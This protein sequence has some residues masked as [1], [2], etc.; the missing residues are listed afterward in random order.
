MIRGAPGPRMPCSFQPN[1]ESAE[2]SPGS[3][4]SV[5]PSGCAF[6]RTG[7]I[8]MGRANPFGALVAGLTVDEFLLL[9]EAVDERR[10]R[11]EDGVGTRPGSAAAY[12]PVPGRPECG[13]PRRLE[14]LF[15]RDR[16]PE[17]A[18]PLLRQRHLPRGNRPRALPQAARYHGLLHQA[19][20]TTSPS[21]ARPS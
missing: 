21:S 18:L 13:R 4:F 16:R 8:H 7:Q 1:R 3:L 10:C 11:E 17:V 12:R 5:N 20:A 2:R 6:R 15:H 9:R 14:G 19:H